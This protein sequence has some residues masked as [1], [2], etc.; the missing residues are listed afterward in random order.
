MEV[1]AFL[2]DGPASRAEVAALHGAIRHA[3][4]AVGRIAAA[5]RGSAR[6]DDVVLGF[7][8]DHGLAMPGAKCTLYDPGLEVTLL[9]AG[10]GIPAGE[11]RPDLVSGVD[12][13]PTLWARAGVDAPSGVDGRD[14]LADGA[15]RDLVFA[16]KTFHG[17]YDPMR[18]VRSQVA[19]LIVNFG[20]GFRVEVPG[21]VDDRGRQ[22]N[23][24]VPPRCH[25]VPE[26]PPH[27]PD[28]S[29]QRIAAPRLSRVLHGREFSPTACSTMPSGNVPGT[30][31]A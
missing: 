27:T 3:D 16:E 25:G 2:A 10:A 1:P 30:V 24:S 20:V 21:D 19:K 8:A 26:R 31:R 4:A 23:A 7:A 28:R 14:L 9:L 15:P 22:G 17:Y 11:R 13:G 5:F 6:A 12:V 29:C 18:A